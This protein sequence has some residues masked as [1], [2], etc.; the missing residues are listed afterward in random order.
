M[1]AAIKFFFLSKRNNKPDTSPA[2][3]VLSR[4]RKTVRTGLMDKKIEVPGANKT[5]PPLATPK[6]KPYKG[7]YNIAPIAIGIKDKFISMLPILIILESKDNMIDKASKIATP[8]IF[9]IAWVVF[10]SR[11]FYLKFKGLHYGR[12]FEHLLVHLV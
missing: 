12:H 9:L 8:T 6:N 7:P 3:P 5:N 2:I 11:I 10:I 4:Q 1:I